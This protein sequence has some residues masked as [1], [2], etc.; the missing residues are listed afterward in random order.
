MAALPPPHSRSMPDLSLSAHAG[1]SSPSASGSA[2]SDI[3]DID[4]RKPLSPGP[5]PPPPELQGGH[6][7][8]A[9]SRD[10]LRR[11]DERTGSSGELAAPHSLAQGQGRGGPARPSM[12]AQRSSDA[13]SLS[14]PRARDWAS[15]PDSAADSAT[16]DDHDGARPLSRSRSPA[17]ST[18]ST[19]SHS[20][21]PSLAGSIHS[22][23]EFA[24]PPSPPPSPPTSSQAAQQVRFLEAHGRGSPA[25]G[26]PRAG[27]EAGRGRQDSADSAAGGTGEEEGSAAELELERAQ[28][29]P[30]RGRRRRALRRLPVTL[31]DYLVA[32]V[33]AAEVDG[34]E[35]IK[36]ERVTNFLTVPKELEKII[37][38]GT[39]I[40][41]DAFLY[42]FTILPLRA[43]WALLLLLRNTLS[44]LL[45]LLPSSSPSSR[46][47]RLSLGHKT[48]LI[49]AG[50]LVGTMAVLHR[51]TDASKMYHGVRGQDTIKLYVLFNVLEIA[52]R[53]CCSFGQDLQDALFSRQT[54]ARRTDGSHPHLRPVALIGLT[55]G[56]VVAHSLVLFYQLVT[57]NVA[58]N[59]YSNALLTLLL[60]NQFVEIKG[61]VFKKF[62][63]EN[64]FQLTCADIVE[65]FQLA[66]MLFIIALRNLI[67]LSSS[68]TSTSP[69]S[70][71]S[72]LP[73]SFRSLPSLSLS[74][75]PSLPTLSLLQAIFSPAVVVLLSECCV[76]WL[77]HAFITKFNHLRPAV[78]GRFVD[79]LCKDLV[80]GAASGE[81]Q[82]SDPPPSPARRLG[83]A[84]LP[85]GCLVV[86][87]LSQALAMMSDASGVD[88]C[89]VPVPASSARGLLGGGGGST[90]GGVHEEGWAG[91][92]VRRGTVVGL[93]AVGLIAL[94]LLL[95]L[96]LR[97]FAAARWA[98]Q[99]SSF[100][101]R[102][103]EENLASR[104]R[105]KIGESE[106]ERRAED[107]G[108]R[109]LE[110][111]RGAD[112]GVEIQGRGKVKGLEE[113]GRYDMVK[114]RLW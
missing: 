56:Y 79:V 50:L 81:G 34:E 83:F 89:A 60:S 109:V 5:S 17:S 74:S 47:R 30:R 33:S 27:G 104:G 25:K 100:A 71:F 16:A 72:F 110:V 113:L 18:S 51:V 21:S 92:A 63:K 55:L 99:S 61:S 112:G 19:R 7:G 13:L 108:R 106:R 8:Q 4:G 43:F 45:F 76:D 54:W 84:A 15:P 67:E 57:L 69:S 3:D 66:L 31:W 91:W 44:N 96:H 77:K 9:L 48:D 64:L 29:E 78:Y 65:R 82:P 32:E 1:P 87:V 53:L 103:S 70:L 52:D 24:A 40:C 26:P 111:G 86:R 12:A 95:S 105:G 10:A 23:P 46:Q 2:E 68:A 11:H 58:I 75:L 38:F 37:F 101:L 39:L 98:P 97:L 42:T 59:S 6:E 102:A 93:V 28:G 36:S 114:S 22:A 14:R 20:T 85:L 88:E 49:K 90:G 73:A 107:E 80:G 94:H 41:L 35:G 62:E